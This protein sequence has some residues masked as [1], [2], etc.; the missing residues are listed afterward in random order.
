MKPM[1]RAMVKEGRNYQGIL[2]GGLMLTEKGVRTIEFNCRF[3]DPETE[4]ILQALR[5]DFYRICTD[6]LDG[7]VPEYSFD[8]DTYLGVVLA[9]TGYPATSTKGVL[10]ENIDEKAPVIFH[11]GTAEKDGKYYTAG[12]RVLFVSGKGRS[13]SEARDNA[14]RS[15]EKIKSEALFHRSDIGFRALKEK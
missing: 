14:Y 9:S 8:E 15:V 5:G 12:G 10:I 13:V 11:M 3:G 4:V 2:Y 7:R 1:T 6:V